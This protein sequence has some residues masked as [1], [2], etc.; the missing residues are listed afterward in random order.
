[1]ADIKRQPRLAVSLE[2]RWYK[3]VQTAMVDRL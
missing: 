3:G 2:G 1:M